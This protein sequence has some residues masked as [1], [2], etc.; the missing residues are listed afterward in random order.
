MSDV[1]NTPA[2]P[3]EY[4]LLPGDPNEHLSPKWLAR[5]FSIPERDLLGALAYGVR[6][7]LVEMRWEVY[8]PVCGRSPGEFGSLKEAYGNVECAAC[9]FCFDLHPDRDLRVTF[10]A[11]E[12][13][14]RL[15]GRGGAP[16][17]LKD[18]TEPTTRGL[19]PLLIPPFWE[20][21][22]GD[23]PADDESLRVG[24]V[25]IL[26]TDL[27][28]S[29][30]MYQERGDPRAYHLVRDHSAILSECI[31]R[32][33][34][35]LI[36]TIG[37]AVMASFA[38]GADAVH[39]ALESQTELRAHAGEIGAELVLKAGVHAGA[40]LAVKLNGRLDLFGGAVNVAARVQGPSC[41]HDVAVADVVMADI[42]TDGVTSAPRTR[43][44]E[45]S[46]AELRGIPIPVSVHRLIKLEANWSWESGQAPKKVIP[47]SYPIR[48]QYSRHRAL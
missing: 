21:F 24:Q 15:R 14:R 1:R 29:T 22:S 9:E 3:R 39:A 36:K 28:G 43:V 26:F 47:S 38:S 31:D 45:S 19:D 30:A 42:E 17:P 6:D 40:C 27:R 2:K 12:R 4:L 46:D 34:G 5:R 25:A 7:G 8:C 20:L 16:L 35:S 32:N 10:S 23:A 18:E 37:D 41:G 11:T 44:A 48:C 13:I 33:R